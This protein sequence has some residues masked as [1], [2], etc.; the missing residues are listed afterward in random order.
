MLIYLKIYLYYLI[1]SFELFFIDRNNIIG[2][3]IALS[4]LL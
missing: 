2:F 1:Y 3:P 4:F